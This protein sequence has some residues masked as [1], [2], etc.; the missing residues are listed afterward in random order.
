MIISY[1]DVR[2]IRFHVRDEIGDTISQI[3]SLVLVALTLRHPRLH[4]RHPFPRIPPR[5]RLRPHLAPRYQTTL[6][7]H[8][9]HWLVAAGIEPLAAGKEPWIALREM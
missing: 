6:P 1:S 9:Q 7:S 5:L 4:L 8:L 3:H 2:E